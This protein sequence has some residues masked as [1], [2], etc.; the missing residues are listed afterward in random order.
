MRHRSRDQTAHSRPACLWIFW[1]KTASRLCRH[2]I[3]AIWEP[4]ENAVECS[5]AAAAACSTAACGAPACL[6]ST[7]LVPARSYLWQL[8]QHTVKDGPVHVCHHPALSLYNVP[9]LTMGSWNTRHKSGCSRDYLFFKC[10]SDML[11][12]K[13]KVIFTLNKLP[14]VFILKLLLYFMFVYSI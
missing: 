9:K 1:E 7:R 10:S 4:D 8:S 11:N 3:W 6:R 12:N 5:A 13:E 14:T 2:W